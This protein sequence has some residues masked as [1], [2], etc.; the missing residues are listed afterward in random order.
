MAKIRYTQLTIII[1]NEEDWRTI[2]DSL[3]ANWDI[4]WSSELITNSDGKSCYV[5]ILSKE[6][7]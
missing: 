2:T 7:G 3:E 6:I 5:F 1:E 4:Y